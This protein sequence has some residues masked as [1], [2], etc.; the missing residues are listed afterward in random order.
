[1]EE[2]KEPYRVLLTDG[3]GEIVEEKSRFIATVRIVYTEEEATAFID[4][5]RKKYW[6]DKV[7]IKQKKTLQL[8]L[9]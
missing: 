2:K 5:M 8:K 3:V 6:N 7:F 4:E 9:Q 1:M